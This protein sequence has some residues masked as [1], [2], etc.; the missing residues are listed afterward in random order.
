[1]VLTLGNVLKEIRIRN[2][3]T[4]RNFCLSRDL[5]ANR[6]SLIE[7]NLLIPNTTEVEEYLKLIKDKR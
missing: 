3:V 4:L 2:E 5:D 7:R 1:M 6:Y